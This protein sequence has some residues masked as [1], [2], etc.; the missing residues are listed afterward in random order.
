MS[1]DAQ[2][3]DPLRPRSLLLP[4]ARLDHEWLTAHMVQHL[5]LMT[6]A[7]PLIVLGEPAL[8][9]LNSLP[10]RCDTAALGPLLRYAPIHGIGRI[11]AN[12][13]FCWLA[14]TVCVI[15]WHVPRACDLC[16]QSRVSHDF[17]QASFFVAGLLFWWP[18]VQ[19]W[20]S[21]AMWHQWSIPL[22]LFLAT[23]SCSRHF[24]LFAVTLSIRLRI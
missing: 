4:L 2:H 13:A 7:G 1:Q 19:P 6:L 15:V 17:E 16:L 20:P 11:L 5:V 22:Y 12:P 21:I 18:V 24:S 9:F 23:I 14:G 8:M 10:E 3:K